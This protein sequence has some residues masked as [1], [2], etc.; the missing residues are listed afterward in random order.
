[1]Q[2]RLL[3]MAGSGFGQIAV[4]LGIRFILYR[5]SEKWI[6]FFRYRLAVMHYLFTTGLLH[7]G[8][9]E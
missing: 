4:D 2:R 3:F 7:R 5:F 1:M 6:V 9:L 8:K